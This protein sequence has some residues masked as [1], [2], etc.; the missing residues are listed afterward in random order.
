MQVCL[1][2]LENK[3]NINILEHINHV[4]DIS[5]HKMCDDCCKKYTKDV[6]KIEVTARNLNQF[7]VF[8]KSSQ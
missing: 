5:L 1:I 2:C 7:L 8:S 3:C 4:G 6:S